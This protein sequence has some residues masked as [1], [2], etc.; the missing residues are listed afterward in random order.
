MIC[1]KTFEN[2]KF[3]KIPIEVREYSE[4]QKE[5]TRPNDGFQ[6]KSIYVDALKKFKNIQLKHRLDGRSKRQQQDSSHVSSIFDIFHRRLPLKKQLKTVLSQ[7]NTLR[8]RIVFKSPTIFDGTYK[9]RFIFKPFFKTWNIWV[10][11]I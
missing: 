3:F 11:F 4:V 10:F 2:I 1:N 5:K 6:F 8:D 9:G 7:W